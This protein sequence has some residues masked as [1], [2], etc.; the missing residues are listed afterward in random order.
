MK[1]IV[2]IIC[3]LLL[4]VRMSSI[5]ASVIPT[6]ASTTEHKHSTSKSPERRERTRQ[7][8]AGAKNRGV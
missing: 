3:V 6:R 2:T 5:L 8:G 7:S 1:K 4:I